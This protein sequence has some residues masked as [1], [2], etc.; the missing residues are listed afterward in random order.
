MSKVAFAS[1]IVVDG[2]GILIAGHYRLLAARKLNLTEVPVAVLD[3]GSGIR[4]RACRKREGEKD[5]A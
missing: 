5:D 4:E 1:P 2:E 3:A